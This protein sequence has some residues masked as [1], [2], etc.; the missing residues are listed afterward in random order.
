M[1]V[2]STSVNE[3]GPKLQQQV[4]ILSSFRAEPKHVWILQV[5]LLLINIPIL[6]VVKPS[7]ILTSWLLKLMYDQLAKL[8]EGE[9]LYL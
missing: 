6:H 1:S 8:N 7:Y 9:W 4:W 3:D 5:V 2:I